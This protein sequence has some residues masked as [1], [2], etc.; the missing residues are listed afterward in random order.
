MYAKLFASLYQGT[1]RGCA[2][3]ILVFTNLLAHAD[4]FGMVDKHWRAIS[5]EVGISRERVEKAI[6]NLEAADP[7]SR[8]PEEEGR[9]IV[10]MDE[11][12]VWGWRI[13]NYGKYRSIR[14]EEDRRTQNRAAQERWRNKQNKPRKPPSAQ[15]EA[16]A[17]ATS[18]EE[19]ES[20]QARP[21][22]G[23][24][25]GRGT[26]LAEDWY[27]SE[28]LCHFASDQGLDPAETRERFRD[29]WIAQPGQRG[30][31]VDWEATWRNWCRNDSTTGKRGS[32]GVRSTRDGG[33]AGAFARAAARLG[34]REPIR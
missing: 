12:R 33:D 19:S 24:A 14:S 4:S 21:T 13:V 18:R 22:K 8:S 28:A 27:P 30:C 31:K 2:D 10:K 34:G 25:N 20:A 11:H 7:D 26:R 29:Y 9:R 17:E 6:A 15:A 1:L 3:E 32:K 16:E 5:E 23:K